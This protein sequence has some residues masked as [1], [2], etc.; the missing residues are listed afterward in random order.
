MHFLA[1]FTFNFLSR[2]FLK[3]LL[4]KTEVKVLACLHLVS[5]GF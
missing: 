3:I 4:K 1:R 5:D 2:L